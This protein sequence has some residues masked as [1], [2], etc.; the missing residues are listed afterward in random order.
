MTKRDPEM[1]IVTVFESDDLIA[2]EMAKAVLD[3]AG[4]DYAVQEDAPAR[5]GFSPILHPIRR[6]LMPAYRREEALGL[7]AEA[8]QESESIEDEDGEREQ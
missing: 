4:V 5:F 3:D 8:Q 6:I 2:F 7:I 1:E